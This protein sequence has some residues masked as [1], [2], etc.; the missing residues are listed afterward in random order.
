MPR[1]IKYNAVVEDR[2]LQQDHKVLDYYTMVVAVVVSH[3]QDYHYYNLEVIVKEGQDPYFV[4]IVVVNAVAVVVVGD[5]KRHCYCNCY[6]DYM[7]VVD[8]IAVADH[9]NMQAAF[10]EDTDRILEHQNDYIVV[11]YHMQVLDTA[12]AAVVDYIHD[13]YSLHSFVGYIVVAVAAAA[14]AVVVAVAAVVV[15]VVVVCS[16]CFGR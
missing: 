10:Q 6:Q 3:Y 4:V 8:C 14:A 2:K 7:V 13:D 9:T 12:A 5:R 16:R 15:V 1:M 11:D